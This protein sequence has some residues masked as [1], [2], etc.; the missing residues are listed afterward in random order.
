VCE[1]ESECVVCACVRE[2]VCGVCVCICVYVGGGERCREKVCDDS[3][4]NF[5]NRHRGAEIEVCVWGGV[6]R[7]LIVCV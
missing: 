7:W 4:G 6:G 3:V 5:L 2:Y 1:S